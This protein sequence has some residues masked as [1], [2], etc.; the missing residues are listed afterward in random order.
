MSLNG[1]LKGGHIITA[2]VTIADKQN[3]SDDFSPALTDYPNDPANIAAEYGRSRADERGDGRAH[4]LE[5]EQPVAHAA[6]GGGIRDPAE[7][8]E[9]VEA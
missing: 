2:S 3:I 6:V 7:P 5:S 4:P 9:A 1:T 8:V